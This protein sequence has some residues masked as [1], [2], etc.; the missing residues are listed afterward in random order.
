MGTT[1][2]ETVTLPAG[3]YKAY[4]V[5][6]NQALRFTF[7]MRVTTGGAVDVYLFDAVDYSDYKNPL[8]SSFNYYSAGTR[9]NTMS[10]SG[11]FSA[12]QA[13]T[14]Y[15]VVDNA[16]I[17]ASGAMGSAPA[18]VEV[19]AQAGT[20]SDPGLVYVGLVVAAVLA[21]GVALIV[22]SVRKKRREAA[23]VPPP[24][25]PWT[26]APWQLPPT[27]SPSTPPESSQ[28]PPRLPPSSPGP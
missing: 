13:G 17:S 16:P 24:A 7:S 12:P 28:T 8:V 23:R 10:F 15:L 21:V 5:S 1:M 22:L 25:A 11:T 26:G 18:T 14:Y 20:P 3:E 6:L 2:S 9:E 27:Q 4:G 19:T